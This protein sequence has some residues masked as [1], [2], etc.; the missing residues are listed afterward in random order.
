MVIN[1]RVSYSGVLESAETVILRLTSPGQG[2]SV[3]KTTGGKR[4]SRTARAVDW[5]RAWRKFS[6]D[7][8]PEIAVGPH[9]RRL[10]CY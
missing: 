5:I 8:D 7:G 4:K 1:T 2:C 10:A 6:L 3:D 9:D